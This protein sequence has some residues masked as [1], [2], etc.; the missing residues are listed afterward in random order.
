MHNSRAAVILGGMTAGIVAGLGGVFNSVIFRGISLNSGLTRMTGPEINWG[1]SVGIMF[2]YLVISRAVVG[3]FFGYLAW[4]AVKRLEPILDKFVPISDEGGSA[5]EAGANV[6]GKQAP[7]A[8][9]E[10]TIDA[11]AV[12]GT[13]IEAASEK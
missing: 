10:K 8:R 5:Q 1:T 9:A 12:T 7:K 4:L 3:I 6:A 2:A 11:G 13:A